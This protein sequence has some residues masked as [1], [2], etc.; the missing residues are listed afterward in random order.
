MMRLAG[1][2]PRV[3]LRSQRVSSA[4]FRDATGWAPQYETI[5]STWWKDALH[6]ARG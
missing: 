3:L 1:S 2:V 4:A 6:A 5:D